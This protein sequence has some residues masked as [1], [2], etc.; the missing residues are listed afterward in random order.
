MKNILIC[1]SLCFLVGC[2][3]IKARS[4]ASIPSGPYVGAKMA[5]GKAARARHDFVF[6]WQYH[7]LNV[8]GSI[9]LDTL[10]LP[11]DIFQKG[12]VNR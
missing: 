4:D 2:S 3:S 6:M 11:Y 10:L 12:K 9:A 1:V 8:A 5:L 7:K